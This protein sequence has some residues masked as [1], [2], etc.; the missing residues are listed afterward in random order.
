MQATIELSDP[1]FHAV[2]TTAARQGM[3]LSDYI[4]E[5]LRD[6]LEEDLPSEAAPQTPETRNQ[7]PETREKT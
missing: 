7:R 2:E 3:R 4:A 5:V 1:L 6:K